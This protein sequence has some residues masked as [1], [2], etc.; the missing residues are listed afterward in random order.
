MSVTAQPSADAVRPWP[1]ELLGRS[2]FLLCKLSNVAKREVVERLAA[3]DLGLPRHRLPH[4]A[5]LSCLVDSGPACQRDVAERLRMDGSDL[6]AVLDEL[7]RAGYVSRVR[8]RRDRRRHA[9]SVTA[10]GRRALGRLDDRVGQADD[11]LFA[12]LTASE[13]EQLH[14]LLRR[15]LGHHDARVPAQRP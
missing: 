14:G 13:R 6:V 1:E 9:V 10:S 5:V 12:P 15:V 3:E 4:L 11:A 2:S 8:D 7:E